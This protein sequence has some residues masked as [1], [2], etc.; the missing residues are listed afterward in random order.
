MKAGYIYLVVIGEFGITKVGLRTGSIVECVDV[1]EN[2][3][4]I[5]QKRDGEYFYI[6]ENRVFEL[7][8]L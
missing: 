5:F 7:G 1:E 4:G 6:S 2:G 3:L 8:P